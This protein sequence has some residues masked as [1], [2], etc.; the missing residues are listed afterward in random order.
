MKM[1]LTMQ[2]LAGVVDTI[3]EAQGDRSS[4][5]AIS[6]RQSHSLHLLQMTVGFRVYQLGNWKLGDEVDDFGLLIW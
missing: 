6:K 4:W 5:L 3:N 1:T 2:K